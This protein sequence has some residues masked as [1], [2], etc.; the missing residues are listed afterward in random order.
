MVRESRYLANFKALKENRERLANKEMQITS[1]AVNR[2]DQFMKNYYKIMESAEVKRRRHAQ[3]M[4]ICR[5]NALN[6]A[7]KGIFIGALEAGTLTDNGIILAESMVETYIKENGGA[8]KILRENKNKTYL[9]HRIAEIVE[10]AA[11]LEAEEIED[12]DT[13]KIL[14][15][16]DDKTEDKKEEDN[17]PDDE[18]VEKAM[19]TIKDKLKDDDEAQKALKVI[20]NKVNSEN[21]SDDEEKEESDDNEE[22]EENKEE[23]KDDSSDKDDEDLDV[24]KDIAGD[25]EPEKSESSDSEEETPVSDEEL[26]D[27]DIP[28]TEAGSDD[29]DFSDG[30]ETSEGEESSDSEEEPTSDEPAA[31]G[32]CRICRP[33]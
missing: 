26:S 4:E 12:I 16:D 17:T 23:E 15:E 10:E 2:R 3:L 19:D 1:E 11:I 13:D 32:T 25:E 27:D 24:E 9:L 14:D 20:Q 6:I 21:S 7:I 33:S 18:E 5:D 8:N 22:S 30:G 29:P 28:D 31:S